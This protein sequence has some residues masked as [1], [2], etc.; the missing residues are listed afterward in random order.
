MA[1]CRHEYSS[2][3][4]VVRMKGGIHGGPRRSSTM[5]GACVPQEQVRRGQNHKMLRVWRGDGLPAARHRWQ[6]EAAFTQDKMLYLSNPI[7]LDTNSFLP[8]RS[9]GNANRW[10]RYVPVRARGHPHKQGLDCEDERLS[11]QASGMPSRRE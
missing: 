4:D 3:R 6:R 10:R 5:E 11:I 2:K 8:L 7:S 1:L 9:P